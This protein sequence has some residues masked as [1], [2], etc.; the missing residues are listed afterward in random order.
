MKRL[1]SAILPAFSIVLP[2][3]A[4]VDLRINSVNGV[5]AKGDSVKVTAVIPS[6]KE[7]TYNL[8]VQSYA[9]DISKEKLTLPAGESVVYSGVF[10]AAISV[11]LNLTP[12][13]NP[14]SGSGIG[15]IVA[16]EDY[17]PGLDVPADLR[18]YWDAELAKM[19]ALAPKVFKS[20]A[21]GMKQEDALDIVCYKIE[22]P[23]PSGNPCR[24]YVA[25]P[26][27][28]RKGS[29]PMHVHFHAAGVKGAHVHAFAKDVVAK[30]KQGFLAV[31]VNAHGILDDQP[32]EYYSDL[33]LGSL[34]DYERRDFSSVEDYYFHNM[35]L[36]DIRAIDYAATLR[37]WDGKRII[38]VGGSQGGGQA[39][40]VAGIDT[41]VTHVLAVNPALT[42]MGG[43]LQGRR[44]GWPAS[45]HRKYAGT[46][47]GPSV[48]AYHD[49]ALLISLFKGDLLIEASNIDAVQDPAAV[50][51]AFNNA[52]SARS[53]SIT[54]FPWAGHSGTDSAHAELYK[55]MVKDVKARFVEGV[56]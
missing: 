53:R 41:R 56:L 28:A 54:F 22:I 40:A 4:G 21:V 45:V 19:R 11:M 6:G 39:L 36:R 9:Q 27:N 12:T 52:G 31:D 23:M 8:K 5:F 3:L 15:F 47:L 1:V 13:S 17:R 35:Y 32:K 2:A 42:D 44:P 38:V 30:A 43:A 7:G 55:K 24:A 46:E 14:R 18:E 49:A 16:P 48:L 50:S 29:L 20:R 51:A 34:K 10:D 33:A 25:Y 26:A 37:C